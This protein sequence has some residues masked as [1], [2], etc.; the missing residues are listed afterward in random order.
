MSEHNNQNQGEVETTGHA[1]DGDLQEYN[2]PLPRWWLWTFYATVIFAVVYWILYPAWPVGDTYTKGLMN[3]ITYENEAGEEETTHWN[4]RALFLKEMKESPAAVRQQDYLDQVSDLSYE[5]IQEDPDLMAFTR[6]YGRGLFGD[7]CAACHQQGGGG[8]MGAYPNLVDDAWLWGGD[9][10]DIEETIHQGRLGYMPPFQETFNEEQL[11]S[12]AAYALSLS[13]H[14]VDQE[15]ASQGEEIFNGPTGGCYQCHTTEGTGRESVGAANLTDSIWTV[16]DVPDAEGI[17]AKMAE[18]KEVIHD[19]IQR[20]MP[21]FGDRL[22][23]DEIRLLTLY[24]HELGG[25]S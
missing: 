5:A 17:D 21:K 15:L 24:V 14:D 19:G 13:G 22:S 4:T 10:A 23:E 20:E 3:T 16:A 25:G 1:W 18:V 2:N 7:N 12:V 9:F 6:S 8:V 11:D